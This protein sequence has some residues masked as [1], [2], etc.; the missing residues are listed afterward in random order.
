MREYLKYFLNSLQSLFKLNES[1]HIFSFE[2]AKA[3]RD[4]SNLCCMFLCLE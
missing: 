3:E 2:T 4:L 1:S